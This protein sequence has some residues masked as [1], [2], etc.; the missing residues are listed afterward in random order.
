MVFDRREFLTSVVGGAAA[1]ASLPTIVP[2]SALGA[3]GAVAPSD[4]IVMACIGVGAQGGG[5]VRGFVKY[6]DVRVA[7]I[8]D[9]SEA[10][11]TRNRRQLALWFRYEIART[12]RSARKARQLAKR[13]PQWPQAVALAKKLGTRSG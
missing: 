1:A 8:C 9:V 2:S 5:H 4:R 3:D 10:A 7:A 12:E 6:S 13:Y 11:V